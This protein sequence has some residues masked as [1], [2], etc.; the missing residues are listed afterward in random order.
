MRQVVI[1]KVGPPEVLQVRES[2]DPEAGAGQIRL[3]V[4][5]AG[6]NFADLMARLGLYPDAPKL[7]CVVGYEASGIVDQ[8]GVGVSEFSI[9]DRVIAV[10][11][12]GAQTDT[13][14]VPA[15]QAF[16]MPATMSFEE[17]AALPVVYL[18]A[19]HMMLYTGNLRRGA[20]VLIHSAAGGVGLAAIQL[21]RIYDCEIFGLA[22]PS[23]H[24]FLRSQGVHHL[25][26]SA[27]AD[28]G[29][30][31]E[32]VRQLVGDKGLDLVLDP[33][34]GSSFN[35]GYKLLGPAGRLVAF[36]FSAAAD[37]PRRSLL[38]VIGQLARTRFWTLMTLM[39][40]NKTLTGVNMGHLFSRLD[41]LRPQ[42]ETLMN[43]Y[44]AGQI[45]PYVDR[46]FSFAEAAAAHQYLHDRKARGKILLVP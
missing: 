38:R 12:F 2:P 17:G 27:G 44:E 28:A 45:R 4:R 33:T 8:V 13:L 40:D 22:S 35:H 7:P 19:H 41:I 23:K 1:T 5:A 18:T 20:R 31:V 24:E 3:K 36:G 11:H 15:E 43:F 21:A 6:I 9:G 29:A 26:D 32:T 46:T 10:P 39:N 42:L 16:R 30:Y 34:G 37:G 25:I 14:V